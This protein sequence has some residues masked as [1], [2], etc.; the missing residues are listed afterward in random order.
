MNSITQQEALSGICDPPPI[1]V[2]SPPNQN[3]TTNTSLPTQGWFS[4]F[5]FLGA[6]QGHR[7]RAQDA[8]RGALRQ[9]VLDAGGD[10]LLYRLSVQFKVVAVKSQAGGHVERHVEEKEK[11]WTS[12]WYEANT[13]AGGSAVS[14][15]KLRKHLEGILD[16]VEGIHH[17]ESAVYDKPGLQRGR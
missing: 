16:L 12:R 14:L 6:N 15:G 8:G 9:H 7:G 2:H 13:K 3:R 17:L 1:P 11:K 5:T 4:C 10:G